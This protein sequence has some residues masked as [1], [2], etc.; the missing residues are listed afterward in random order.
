[1]LHGQ[2]QRSFTFKGGTT[3]QHVIEG[4]S[5][6]IQVA[7]DVDL[8]LLDL[9]RTHVHRCPQRGASMRQM[10]IVVEQDPSQS[11]IGDFGIAIGGQ[12][13]V[14]RFDIAVNDTTG[15]R[16]GQRRQHL[17]QDAQRFAQWQLP[18]VAN[19]QEWLPLRLIV[20]PLADCISGLARYCRRLLPGMYS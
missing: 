16:F 18:I 13:D 14:F 1:M 20:Q 15:C 19:P 9:L 12:H 10:R 3:T 6:R 5:Q 17:Q 11:E 8:P 2:S 7:A 4:N